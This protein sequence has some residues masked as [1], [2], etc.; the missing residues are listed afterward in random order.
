MVTVTESTVPG[1][2]L[3]SVECVEAAGGSPN[4]PN[5][6]V[7]LANRR[8]NILVEDGETVTCTF[9]SEPLAPT[10][11]DATVSGRVVTTR[12]NPV[13]GVTLSLFNAIT[14]ETKSAVTNNFGFYVFTQ[15]D[16]SQFYVLTAYSNNRHVIAN[17]QR[18]FTLSDDLSNVDFVVGSHYWLE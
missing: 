11:G 7:D 4:V 12:G 14:G 2:R 18:S 3:A 5:T 15:L 1:W 16:V 6:T 9:T 8:A 10:A 17:N 13:R